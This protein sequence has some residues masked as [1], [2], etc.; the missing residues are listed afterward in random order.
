MTQGGSASDF[1]D[2]PFQIDALALAAV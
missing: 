2:A 1:S